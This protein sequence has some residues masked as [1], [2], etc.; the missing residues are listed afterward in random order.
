LATAPIIHVRSL[1]KSFTLQRGWRETLRHPSRRDTRV[2]L[3]DISFD[4]HPGEFFGLLGENGA[5]KTTLFKILA[6]LIRPDS[7]LVSVGGF[8]VEDDP[9]EIRRLLIPVIPNERSLYWRLSAKE[10]LRLYAALYGLEPG[11]TL[12]RIA[13]VLA[14]VGLDG[15][16]A[17]QVGLF[18]SGM[19]QR[20]MIGRA[21]LGR[22][23]VLLL[24][25]PTR[26]LDPVSARELRTFLKE[27]IGEA[28]G[29]TVLLATHDHEEVT[30]L[31]DR[32]AVL[33]RG[34]LL[35]VGE[36]EVLLAS[37]QFRTYA[38]WTTDPKH[39]ALDETVARIGGRVLGVTP[40]TTSDP[41]EW[42]RIRI[43]VPTNETG[44]AEILTALVQ[45]GSKVSRF[46]REDLSLADLLERVKSAHGSDR[47]ERAR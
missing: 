33:D 40:V 17:K 7:G 37:S 4:V 20:L 36:T 42:Y 2:A 13:D 21:L 11:E 8:G 44:A 29:T 25:E 16:G 10:N 6:T 12:R 35:A 45:S 9:E 46:T 22:P 30:E 28:H 43:E 32:V 18:S 31:C 34:R 19:K 3:D 38:I 47:V 27:Q 39:A 15:V 23:S 14:L 41:C 5:G 26:S 24:D 1:R